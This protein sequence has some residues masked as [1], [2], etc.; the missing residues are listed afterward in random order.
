MQICYRLRE[1]VDKTVRELAGALQRKS[2][3]LTAAHQSCHRWWVVLVGVQLQGVGDL[4]AQPQNAVNYTWLMWYFSPLER[5]RRQIGKSCWFMTAVADW[6]RLLTSEEEHQQ[7]LSNVSL[8]KFPKQKF[9]QNMQIW[10]VTLQPGIKRVA[11]Q[12]MNY[13]Y[14]STLL[15]LILL[16]LITQYDNNLI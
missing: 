11:E 4:H 8:C 5:P 7:P 6:Q 2:V 1:W 15:H 16:S 14:P 10:F 13:T 9:P 3:R 12:T